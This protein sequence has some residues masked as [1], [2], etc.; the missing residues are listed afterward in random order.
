M[1]E[2]GQNLCLISQKDVFKS[3]SVSEKLDETLR[4]QIVSFQE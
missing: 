2:G 1:V 4:G 3:W